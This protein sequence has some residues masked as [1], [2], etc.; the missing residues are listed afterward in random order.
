[1]T[2]T[3]PLGGKVA[4]GVRWAAAD[5]VVQQVARIAI[6]V[7]L[8]KLTSPEDYGLIGI[9]FVVTQISSF[10]T[11]LGM[12]PALIQR[13]ELRPAHVSTALTSTFLFSLVL[14]GL[15][16]VTARPVSGFFNEPDLVPV[17]LVLSL[18]FPLKGMSAI[19]RDMLRRDLLFRPFVISSGV[20]VVGSGALGIV[21]AASGGGVWALVAYSVGESALTILVATVLAVRA[22]VF[23]PAFGFE[24]EAFRDLLGFGASV[25]AFKL[26]YYA[27]INADNLLVGKVL[28]AAALGF[29]GLAYRL[30]LYPIQKVADVISQVA[31]PAFA[32]LQH[33]RTR[34]GA[35]FERAVQAVSLVCFPLSIGILVASPLL[36]PVVFGPQW[37]PAITTVQIL[38][39]NGPRM[40]VNRLNGAVFQ[41]VGKPQWDLWVAVVGLAF[42]IVAFAVGIRHGIEGMAVAYTVAGYLAMPV[43]QVL[44]TRLVGTTVLKNLLAVRHLALATLLMA[45]VAEGTRRL[46]SDAAS[47]VALAAV[48]VA[49]A[50]TYAGGVLLFARPVLRRTVDDVLRRAS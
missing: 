21:I 46:M 41:G 35:N 17:L 4:A 8:T 19:P 20:A 27:Q 12:G 15:V 31:M 38:S 32:T 39:L 9:A 16:V 5:Q 40:A 11:D 28:G 43:S 13:R 49:G 10:V 18:N 1:V 47:P 45:L 26:V 2:D 14:A 33:D 42:Y 22:G 3:A 7:V 37:V 44:A 6:T 23:R 34:L 50:V 48:V 36:V 30:M 29:Y 25:S 24:R